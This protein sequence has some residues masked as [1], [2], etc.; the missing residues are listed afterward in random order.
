M[1]RQAVPI[2]DDIHEGMTALQTVSGMRSAAT[3][4]GSRRSQPRSAAGEERRTPCFMSKP[5]KSKGLGAKSLPVACP[6]PPQ[7]GT[8]RRT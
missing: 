6:G 8:N 7:V 3:G 5:P 4:S 1:L 2:F